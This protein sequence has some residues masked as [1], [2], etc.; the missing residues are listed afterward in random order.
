MKADVLKKDPAG[1]VAEYAARY[2]HDDKALLD[3]TP[4]DAELEPILAI[5][6]EAEELYYSAPTE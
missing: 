1:I 4:T 3:K 5:R 2:F 6:K